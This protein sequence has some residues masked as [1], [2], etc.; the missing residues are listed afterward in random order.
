MHETTIR[1]IIAFPFIARR[2][3][4]ERYGHFSRCRQHTPPFS[5]KDCALIA[6]STGRRA[7]T[8]GEMCEHLQTVSI[9]SVY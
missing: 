5:V 3:H 1:S 2:L 4:A 7:H 6:I 9:D 8:L